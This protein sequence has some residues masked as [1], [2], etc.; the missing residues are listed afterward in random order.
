M[1]AT[2]SF[3]LRHRHHALL[4]SASVLAFSAVCAA[5]PSVAQAAT[6]HKHAAHSAAKKVKKPAIAPA[7]VAATPQRAAAPVQHYAA[8]RPARMAVPAFV[9]H[10]VENVIVTGS[11]L[12]TARNTSANPVQIVTAK[13]IQ[14]TG[15]S[16]LSEFFQRLPSVGSSGTYNTQ[17]NGTGGASCLDLRN[18]GQ[19]RVLVLIDGKRTTLNGDSNCVDLNAIPLQQVASVEILKDGGSELYGADAV[20]GVVN[21]KLRHDL[22][23]ANITIKGSITGYGDNPVGQISGYKGWNFDHGKGNLTLFGSYMTQGGIM[24]RNRAWA[25]TPQ[26]NNPASASS[27]RYGSSITPSGFLI[28]NTSGNQYSIANGQSTTYDGKRYNFGQ[29]QSL[30]NA[31]QDSN[32]TADTHYELNKHFDFYGNA[33]YGHKTSSTF[34]AA[35]PIASVPTSIYVPANYPGNLTGEDATLYRRLTEYG[36][37]RT[38]T[39]LDTFTG[40]LGVQGEI[41]HQWMYDL[42]YTYGKSQDTIQTRGVGNYLNTMREFGL[43]PSNL[44]DLSDP[45]TT[46]SYNPNS[47]AGY[48]GCVQSSALEPLSKEAAAYG[49]YTSRAHT[50]YQLR[51]LNLRIHNNHVV[52]MPWANGGDLGIALGMEHRG[53]QLTQTPDP[54][55]QEG[56]TFGNPVAP[57]GG[58]FNVSEGYAQAHVQLLKNAMLAHDLSIDVQ[59]RYSSYNTFGNAKN[60]KAGINWAPTQDIRFR[61]TIGTSFRQPN[62]YESYGGQAISFNAAT[63]PCAQASSYGA[64]ANAVTANCAARGINTATFQQAGSGQIP[65]ITGGNSKLHPET[66]RTYTFGAVLTPHWIPGLSTSAEFWH[67]TVN[68][69]IGS[70]G[71]QYIV[72]SCYTGTDTAQCSNVVRSSNGQIATVSAVDQNIG[73]MI[74]SG[75]DWDTNYRFRVSPHDTLIVDNNFQ[76][77][78][79]YKQQ[80][81]PGGQYYDFLGS[82]FYQGGSG[83]PITRDYATLTWQH[84][85]FAVNYMMQYTSGMR[86]N[87]G[88][89]DIVA[90]GNARISTPAMVQNDISFDYSWNKWAFTGGIQNINNKKPPF[91]VDAATNTN[92]AQY[93]GFMYGRTFFLQ[94]GLNF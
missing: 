80:Q 25:A 1:P 82:I 69:M 9:D 36:N 72:D 19:N 62:V 60:W 30:V 2:T 68:G 31:L 37:R 78:L 55:V 84:G 75:I 57:T 58:G 17:T 13:Q 63:D 52:Q 10:S 45:N 40:K 86:W 59:G 93:G 81:T 26:S 16:T 91:L 38:T 88:T 7:A 15:A 20:S 74:E 61:G 22:N 89:N 92:T 23:D 70:L 71:T 53:E 67:Y 50:T 76:R 27:V 79:T 34:M 24:Q 87:N 42:S 14:N 5:A 83:Q 47:C 41:V 85:H 77:L 21:I 18:L 44:S 73:T 11:A 35:Q 8:A 66:G 3:K 90:N 94:A 6:A 56:N 32:L 64:L 4:L 12:S 33:Q 51:D 46:Y 43:V 48:T 29:E 28:G 54:M 49:N 65:T 39:A